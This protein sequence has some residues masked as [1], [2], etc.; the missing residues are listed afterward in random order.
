ML[1]KAR[2]PLLVF[3]L[4]YGIPKWTCVFKLDNKN[5]FVMLSLRSA[6]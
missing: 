4:E 1:K 3:L 5:L 6:S 2:N